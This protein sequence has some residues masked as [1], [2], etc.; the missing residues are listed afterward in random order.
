MSLVLAFDTATEDTALAIGRFEGGR[1]TV[2]GS[3]DFH[4]PRAALSR[5][6]PAIG[7]LLSETGTE[8][9]SISTV[10]VGRGPGS[11]TGVRIGVATAKGLTQGLGARLV[12][13]GTLDAIA[14]RFAEEDRLVGVVGDAMRGEVYPALFRCGGGACVRL[15]P[16]E[17]TFPQDAASAWSE[18]LDE[19]GGERLLLAGNGLAKHASVFTDVLGHQ[20]EIAIPERWSPLG[21]TLL[22]AAQHASSDGGD[23]A[24][25][26]P[27]Y[28]RLSDAE[29]AERQRHERSGD[30]LPDTGVAGPGGER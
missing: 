21:A 17:V 4:A 1:V 3:R 18:R 24:A 29:E 8:A 19:S 14:W 9:L 28:T 10:V 27:I 22:R 16:D 26:L 20:A 2:L 7:E 15:T 12:G 25:L 5:L 30:R 13:V 23:P 11:F 6:V